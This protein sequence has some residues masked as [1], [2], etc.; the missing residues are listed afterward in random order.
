LIFEAECENKSSFTDVLQNNEDLPSKQL[1][2]QIIKEEEKEE[3][4]RRRKQ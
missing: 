1:I 2:E 4:E 3:E